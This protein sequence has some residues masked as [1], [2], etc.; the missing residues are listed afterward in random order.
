MQILRYL[1]N[2]DPQNS[3]PAITVLSISTQD[4]T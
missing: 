1:E 3:F 4:H 2:L